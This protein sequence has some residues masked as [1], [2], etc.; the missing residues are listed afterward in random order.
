MASTL[1]LEF[2]L[3]CL[4]PKKFLC[5]KDSST[6]LYLYIWIL[7]RGS[8]FRSYCGNLVLF[9]VFISFCLLHLFL[10]V[11]DFDFKFKVGS[12]S[13]I[14]FQYLSSYCFP[15]LSSPMILAT[16]WF[17]F[18]VTWLLTLLRQVLGDF[19][20]LCQLKKWFEL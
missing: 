10:W 15:K 12:I 7:E 5:Y 11:G 13:G 8:L 6:Y 18:S 17:H 4:I 2:T 9:S 16:V 19:Y 20:D 1:N 3:N 14:V